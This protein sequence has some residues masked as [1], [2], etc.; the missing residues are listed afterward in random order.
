[1]GKLRDRMEEDL[2]LRNVS[3]ATRKVYLLYARKFIAHWRRPPTELGEQ[4]VR[5]W[6]LHLMQVE[7]VSY[8][9]YRQCLAAVKFLYKVTLGRPCAVEHIP[10]PQ[11]RRRLPA[12]L[13]HEQVAAALGAV[14]SLKYRALLMTMYAS[15]PRISEACRLRVQD[16][17]STRMVLRV[18]DGK[19]GK[20]RQAPPRA[21]N[22]L[23]FLSAFPAAIGSLSRSDLA[24]HF[25]QSERLFRTAAPG[26][27]RGH[28]LAG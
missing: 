9:T 4:E 23:N 24:I 6:L 3:P 27:R 12:V 2:K 17:D 11:H 5:Q 28:Q 8:E 20:D 22:L 19:G 13:S 15:G 16:I 14:Q 18:Q 10:F 7:L 1:M 25:P 26:A 21:D